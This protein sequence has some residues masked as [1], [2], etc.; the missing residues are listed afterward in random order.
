MEALTGYVKAPQLQTQLVTISVM[1]CIAWFVFV[2]K[3]LLHV[4][5]SVPL[6]PM[7]LL[8]VPLSIYGAPPCTP[9]S[10]YGGSSRHLKV[11]LALF[12]VL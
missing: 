3:A 8:P 9:I 12:R 4:P 1:S 11:P 5:L 7:T 2:P 10:V 6:L